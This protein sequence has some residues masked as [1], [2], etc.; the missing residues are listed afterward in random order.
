MK[1]L[2]GI[3]TAWI[4]GSESLSIMVV[5]LTARQ[6]H[7]SDLVLDDKLP[8]TRYRKKKENESRLASFLISSRLGYG[9]YLHSILPVRFTLESS[10]VVKSITHT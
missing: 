8:N 2:R 4:L 7:R 3:T 5:N 9:D 10:D 6:Q 1:P